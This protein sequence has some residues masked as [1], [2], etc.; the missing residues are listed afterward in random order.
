MWPRAR[1][2][3]SNLF[4][5]LLGIA[6]TKPCIEFEVSSSSSFKDTFDRIPKIV[7]VTWPRPRPFSGKLF[8]RQSRYNIGLRE[9][10][11]HSARSLA[12]RLS[13]APP[14]YG[15][16]HQSISVT[17]WYACILL[18]YGSVSHIHHTLP[19]LSRL[20]GHNP[21]QGHVMGPWRHTLWYHHFNTY[22]LCHNGNVVWLLSPLYVSM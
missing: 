12:H 6:H 13:L 4:V 15:T 21:T 8:V 1:P 11:A 3:S 5:R 10:R 9:Q 19:P 16:S 2:L 22:R 14:R 17:L 7:G 20:Y 18:W